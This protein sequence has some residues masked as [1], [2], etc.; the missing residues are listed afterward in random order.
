MTKFRLYYDRME[1]D[2]L[3]K[4]SM[5]GWKF[6]NFFLGFYTFSPCES[7]EYLYQIDLLENWTGIKKTSLILW[8]TAALRLFPNGIAGCI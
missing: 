3:L 6:E 5:Q 4:M 8:K 7:G 1:Q 2:W